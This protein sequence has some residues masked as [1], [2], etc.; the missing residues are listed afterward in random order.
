VL[1]DELV[2][3]ELRAPGAWVRDTFGEHP[4]GRWEREQWEA[5]VRRVAAYRSQ[6]EISDPSDAIGPRPE[7]REQRHDWRQAREAIDHGERRL[8]RDVGVDRGMD[9][10]IG[11]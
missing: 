5:G 7:Q 1:R 6:Y 8:G 4:D 9:L 10:D 11:F 2:E 3:R